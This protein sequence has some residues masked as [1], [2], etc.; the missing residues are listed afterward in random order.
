MVKQDKPGKFV[1]RDAVW[2]GSDMLGTGVAS[3]S[4]MSGVHFQNAASW[5]GYVNSLQANR[6]PLD[7]A[8]STT[9]EERLTREMI[10]QLKLGKIE[11][12]HF[13]EKF[14]TDILEVF[15]STYQKLQD[16]GMLTFDEDAVTLTQKG[17][18]RV[19]GLLPEFYA[20]KYRNARYT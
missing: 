12:A 7:R 14:D 13:R 11:I 19:D 15:G 3:F 17:L 2:R 4:H 10:L 9:P 16:E 18:L 20:P 6:L 8:F 5:D 1:Y